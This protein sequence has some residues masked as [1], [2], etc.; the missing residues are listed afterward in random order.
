MDQHWCLGQKEH[1]TTVVI[2]E[3]E[4]RGIDTKS[5]LNYL[6]FETGRY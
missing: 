2:N 4:Q 6:E 3:N 5:S 1:D